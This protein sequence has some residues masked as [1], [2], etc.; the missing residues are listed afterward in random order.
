MSLVERPVDPAEIDSVM[1]FLRANKRPG[2]I[3]GHDR[4]FLVW[5]LSPGRC[6][7][8]EHAGLSALALWDGDEIVGLL[9]VIGAKFN[10]DGS[11]FDGGWLC[12]LIVLP[13]YRS[14]GGWMRLM[15]AVH[16]LPLQVVGVVGFP[17]NVVQLYRAMGYSIQRLF[18]FVRI[19]DA[20]QVN[21]IAPWD[22]WRAWSPTAARQ[23]ASDIEVASVTTLDERWDRFWQRFAS[24]D[25][26]GPHRDSAYMTWRYLN[27]PRL[28]HAVKLAFAE[29]GKINGGAVYRIEPVKGRPELVLRLLELISLDEPTYAALLQSIVL[30]GESLRVAFIDH[31]TSRPLHPV[32]E[33]LGWMEESAVQDAVLP[34]LFQPLVRDRHNVNVG[35]RLLGSSRDA[36]LLRGLHVVKSDGDQDRPS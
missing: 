25:Y 4:D 1:A 20:E 27:H 3:L 18:R 15:K 6:R 19:L 21:S 22:G 8:F 23:I 7:G 2:H 17:F 16:H 24:T 31:Y 34:G 30:D 26:F 35:I 33:K 32:F 9:G 13:E 29:N 14:V 11:I 5:Q 28:Q 36:D 10:R 12:N